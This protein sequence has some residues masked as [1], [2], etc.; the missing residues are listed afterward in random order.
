MLILGGLL[1]LAGVGWGIWTRLNTPPAPQITEAGAVILAVTAPLQAT[2]APYQPGLAHTPSP[3][4]PAAMTAPPPGTSGAAP[5]LLPEFPARAEPAKPTASAAPPTA[6]PSLPPTLLPTPAPSLPATLPPAPAPQPPAGT[7]GPNQQASPTPPLRNADPPTRIVAPSIKLD[8]PVVPMGWE[9]VDSKGALV[10]QWVVPRKA[11]GWH[12]NSALPGR[13]G[14]VVLSGHH[15]I[16]GKVFRYVVNLEMAA[17]ITLY[18]GDTPYRY[19]ATEKYI[20]KEAG[21]SLAVRKKNA[22]WIMPTEDERLTLVTCWP[23]EY[24]GNSHRV[25]VVARPG[26]TVDL[27]GEKSY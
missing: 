23:Y 25:I 14:N 24:P 22:Q 6:A 11:A 12:T 8:A 27:N 17:E 20:L 26:S 3:A 19:T 2:P 18:V 15:N 4:I 21:M 1:I 16:E 13:G 10:P 9:M 7:P 5:E